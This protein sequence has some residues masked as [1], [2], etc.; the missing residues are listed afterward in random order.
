MTNKNLP[1]RDALPEGRGN[2]LAWQWSAYGAAHTDRRNLLIHAV[3]T[4]LFMLGCAALPASFAFGWWLAPAGVAVISGAMLAQ[5]RG[6]ARES[7]PPAPF[8]GPLDVLARILAEQWI[9]FPRF[10]MSGR[11]FAAWRGE[12]PRREHLEAQPASR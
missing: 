10:F 2:L 5:G 4:P 1:A 12:A 7:E 9:T 6:H 8:L 3:T 11:F